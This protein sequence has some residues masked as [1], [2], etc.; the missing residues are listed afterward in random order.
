LLAFSLAA[1]VMVFW[2][3]F[4]S[5]KNAW[6]LPEY[7]HGPLIP[8]ISLFLFMREMRDVPPVAAPVT[9][10]WPGVAMLALGL[11]IGVMGN[12]AG[13]SHIVTYGFIVWLAGMVLLSF[14]FRR[15][16][17]FWPAVVHLVFML[18]LPTFIYWQVSTYLQFVSSEIGVWVI[19][20]LGIPVYLDGNVIDLGA[21]KLLVAEACSGLRYLFPM[22]SFSYVFAVL[23]QGP[24]WHKAI[25]LL[26]AAPITVAMNSFRIGMIGVM[27]DRFGI[28]QAEGFLHTFEG[29][30]IFIACV[31]ILFIEASVLQ[32]LARAPRPLSETLDISFHG[33]GA[34]AR[35]IGDVLPSRA[36][37]TA[38]LLTGVTAVGWFSL[39][40]RGLREVARDPFVIFPQ[41][42]GA[43]QG[44]VSGLLDPGIEQVL[45]A[46]D[47]Y[48]A[49]FTATG[50]GAPVDLFMAFYNDQMDG[51][52]IHSPEVCIP[53]GGWEVSAWRS[54]TLTL[55]TGE[56][57]GV[58]RAIIQ[59]G[60]AR[61]LVYYWFNLRGERIAGDFAAKWI[62]LR[63]SILHGRSDG[64][65]VRLITPLS[66]HEEEPAADARLQAFMATL[67][68]ALPR[69]IPD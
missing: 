19:A 36:L 61:Q 2:A 11:G 33:F 17:M 46:D 4:V 65:L 38:A 28:A 20:A 12:L 52:G 31:V 24:G 18:P 22:L 7:S 37:M 14:G 35:R 1:A 15:G 69:F 29:W 44:R 62:N 48:S 21:Y 25:L 41:D 34:Q 55:P 53:A 30:I 27:V 42:I 8:F 63:D 3:G 60:V 23:Y 43:W 6:A 10:R 39:P 49:N 50:A 58:S 56:R 32:R 57:V 9:D 66:A 45:A 26:S 64:A 5:L 68:P 40:E 47:Y 67:M 51:T 13:I 16:V 54:E 59:K